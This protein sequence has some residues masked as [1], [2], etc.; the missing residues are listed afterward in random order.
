MTRRL[1]AVL[2]DAAGTLIHTAEPVGETYA[3]LAAARGVR[4]SA[5]RLD[6]AF[7]RVLARAA[8]LVFPDAD[9]DELPGCERR[10]WWEIVR[11]T[12][13]AADSSIRFA[14]F[15]GGFDAYFDALWDHFRDPAAWRAGDGAR[16]LLASLRAEGRATGVVSNFDHRLEGLLSGLGLDAELDLV[17]RPAD[18]GAAKPDPRIFALALERLGVTAAEA[19][20]VGDDAEADVAG[21][22]KA[23][24]HAVDV[25]C[26]ATLAHLRNVIRDLEQDES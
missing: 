5:E 11:A 24:L 16:A 6:E 10:W 26:L 14:D 2:F 23:G 21:A 15:E 7:R 25:G 1:R 18:A 22:R 9:E 17:L 13:R 19:L 8:P 4:L 3:R 20:Y 12:W